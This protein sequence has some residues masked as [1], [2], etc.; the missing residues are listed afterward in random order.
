MLAGPCD[1]A[2]V[3]TGLRWTPDG[4]AA[5]GMGVAIDGQGIAEASGER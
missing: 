5:L 2:L 1:D 4:G 3:A